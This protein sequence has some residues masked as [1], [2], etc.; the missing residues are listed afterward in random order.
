MGG[1]PWSWGGLAFI[2]LLA[3]PSHCFRRGLDINLHTHGVQPLQ[4][5]G[6]LRL[7]PAEGARAPAPK[8]EL[9][10]PAP[11][12]SSSSSSSPILSSFLQARAGN[13]DILPAALTHFQPPQGSP[14]SSRPLFGMRCTRS[15]AMPHRDGVPAPTTFESRGSSL[16]VGIGAFLPNLPVYFGELRG[17][18]LAARWGLRSEF[19]RAG[20]LQQQ[21]VGGGHGDHTK[22]PL[23]AL[24]R[25][26]SSWW[27]RGA[28][29]TGQKCAPSVR[30][31]QIIFSR[32]PQPWGHGAGTAVPRF[33]SPWEAPGARPKALGPPRRAA[34]CF[35]RAAFF[36]FPFLNST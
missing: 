33:A 27:L 1:H 14:H 4:G 5:R 19:F 2:S 11:P 15:R 16:R 24:L 18:V 35:P 36:C 10:A 3:E 23:L 12:S 13:A 6:S 31:T 8:L 17:Q 9:Q 26:C 21:L 28:M 29:A 20:S 7:P 30:L 34:L 25:G 22:P 32:G